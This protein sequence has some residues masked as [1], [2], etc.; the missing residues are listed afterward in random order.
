MTVPILLLLRQ[1]WPRWKILSLLAL[2][3]G[4]ALMSVIM[5]SSRGSQLAVAAVVAYLVAQ[6]RYRVRGLAWA[7]ILLP[8]LWLITPPEQKARFEQMGED[9]SSQTRLTYWRHG[10]EIMDRYPLLGI[11]YENWVPYYRQFYNP[12]GQVPH[13]IFI[14]AGAQMGYSGLVVFILLIVA[15]FVVNAR[16]R[17][18]A[19]ALPEWGAFHRSLAFGLDAA[20]VGYLVAGFFVTV[21]FYPFFW[22]NLSMTSALHLLVERRHSQQQAIG[23]AHGRIGRHGRRRALQPT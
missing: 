1:R 18:M 9:N 6:T 22:M 12:V 15:T 4:T 14:E 17:R 10:L 13:N 19:R 8:A 2:L 3:P 5:S 23:F 11:G 21:L 7:A 16:T 20:L